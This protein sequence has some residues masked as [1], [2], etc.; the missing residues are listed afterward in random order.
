MLCVCAFAVWVTYLLH[1][2]CFPCRVLLHCVFADYAELEHLGRSC[3][4]NVSA[5]RMLLHMHTHIDGPGELVDAALLTH[6]VFV[7]DDPLAHRC[8]CSSTRLASRGP[9]VGGGGE[10]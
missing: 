2:T 5:R 7:H 4:K 10:S 8:R 9:I 6:V 3:T 1:S